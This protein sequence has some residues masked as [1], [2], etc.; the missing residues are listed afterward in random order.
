[1]KVFFSRRIGLGPERRAGADRLG[2]AAHGPARRVELRAARRAE[3]RQ[4]SSATESRCR[5][6]TGR[7]CASP[8]TSASA[9]A[10]GRSSR[11]GTTATTTTAPTASI[12]PTSRPPSSASRATPPAATTRGP[13]ARATGREAAPRSGR[14]RSGT[15][16]SASTTSERTSTR[17]RASCC[18]RASIATWGGSPTSRGPEARTCS[19]CTSRST[20][21]SSRT[22]TGEV[23][24]ER[25]RL[26]F[27]GL[28]TSKASEAYLYLV[29]NFERLDGAV[30]DRPGRRDRARRATASTTWACAT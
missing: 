20:A 11:S 10:S 24:S 22:S 5:A 9:R 3:R 7:R 6:T 27:L 16:A 4:P 13:G 25:H 12:S 15:R 26:D 14:A 21:G 17:R 28:R 19:T 29:D 1:M 18:A 30:R 2:R 23:E 8:A